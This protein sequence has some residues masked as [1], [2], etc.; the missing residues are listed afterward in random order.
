VAKDTDGSI[1]SGASGTAGPI[2]GGPPAVLVPCRPWLST[3]VLTDL[4]A[5]IRADWAAVQYDAG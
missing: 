3:S 2:G 1:P 4:I 5:Q